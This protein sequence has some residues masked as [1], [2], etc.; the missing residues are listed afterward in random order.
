M[1]SGV[2]KSYT[3]AAIGAVPVLGGLAQGFFDGREAANIG[4]TT[5]ENCVKEKYK[6]FSRYSEDQR[7][8]ESAGLIEQSAVT[9]F[10]DKYYAKNPL[11]H[12]DSGIVA[13]YTGMTKAQAEIALGL[14][15]YNL[16]LAK[17]H[18]KERGPEKPLKTEDYQY[19]ST[20]V[21]AE[22]MPNV[23]LRILSDFKN[24]RLATAS[25]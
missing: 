18:P 13:R 23:I 10:L 22:S 9:G 19:E 21:I 14:V 2:I 8:L 6:Y 11:D 7:V 12:S 16:F 4:W 15:E 25:A 5:G 1:G 17:Y 3:G 20:T 24:Q